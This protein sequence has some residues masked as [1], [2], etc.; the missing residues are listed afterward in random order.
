MR[1]FITAEEA[2]TLLP[3]SDNIH[4]FIQTPVALLGA[5]WSREYIIDKL[6]T[7][8]KIELAGE[9]ARGLGHG[10]AFYNNDAKNLSEVSF[11]ETD[12]KKL[13]RFDPGEEIEN[14]Q[15]GKH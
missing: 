13:F 9:E 3:D 5:E 10:L 8:D 2:V 6:K 14:D 11:V 15:T 1:R 4:T 12:I 7:S